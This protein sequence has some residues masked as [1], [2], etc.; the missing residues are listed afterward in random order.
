MS[1]QRE[2]LCSTLRQVRASG[3][4]TFDCCGRLCNCSGMV[5]RY[6]NLCGRS[7]LSNV[8]SLTWDLWVGVNVDERIA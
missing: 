8:P 7:L 3:F 2:G 1:G 5:H 4:V 6:L